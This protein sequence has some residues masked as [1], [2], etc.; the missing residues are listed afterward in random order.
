MKGKGKGRRQGKGRQ[1]EG[2]A[3]QGKERRDEGERQLDKN[4]MASENKFI[5]NMYT[6]GKGEEKQTNYFP[7]GT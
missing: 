5:Y 2:K 6:V 3:R 4:T 1:G 7:G